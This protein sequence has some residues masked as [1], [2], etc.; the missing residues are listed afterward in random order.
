MILIKFGERI[1]K[2]IKDSELL[3]EKYY[4][5]LEKSLTNA[6]LTAKRYQRIVQKLDLLLK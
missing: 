1:Q 3:E 4:E 2:M 6:K 5:V